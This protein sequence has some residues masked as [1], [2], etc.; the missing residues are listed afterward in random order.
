MRMEIDW[1]TRLAADN[2]PEID[3]EALWLDDSITG[4][5]LIELDPLE[6]TVDQL[7]LASEAT[8]DFLETLRFR[9][10][11]ERLATA[12][13]KA[14]LAELRTRH[15]GESAAELAERI[16]RGAR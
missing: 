15:G 16:G 11:S 13:M 9:P 14:A 1:E 5:D 7:R 10:L 12:M 2:E 8:G 3:V 4:E 6:E